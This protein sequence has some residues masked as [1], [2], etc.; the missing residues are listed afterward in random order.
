MGTNQRRQNQHPRY[1]QDINNN[2][3]GKNNENDDNNEDEVIADLSKNG[4][5]YAEAYR[6]RSKCETL[7]K[8]QKRLYKL[9]VKE[10]K[11]MT[12]EDLP[13]KNKKKDMIKVSIVIPLSKKAGDEMFKVEEIK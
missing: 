11:K 3:E 5:L 2:G 1:Q 13:R 9:V 6:I 10:I 4:S 7:K 12:V 8:E